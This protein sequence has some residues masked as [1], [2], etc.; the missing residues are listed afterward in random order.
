[1]PSFGQGNGGGKDSSLQ[2]EMHSGKWSLLAFKPPLCQ[3]LCGPGDHSPPCSQARKQL[4]SMPCLFLETAAARPSPRRL[5]YLG[6]VR[7]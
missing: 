3:S 5:P 7:G 1:M 6:T 2:P 4:I